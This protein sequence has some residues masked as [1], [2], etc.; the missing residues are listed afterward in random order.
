MLSPADFAADPS[1]AAG[2]AVACARG[3][4]T[5]YAIG[6]T[7][8]LRHAGAMN[9]SAKYCVSWDTLSPLNSMMLT[10]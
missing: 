5:R 6:S 8:C 2:A 9:G 10:V 3:D 1:K 7:H 4:K